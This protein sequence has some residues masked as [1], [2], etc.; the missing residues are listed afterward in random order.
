[1]NKKLLSKK[2]VLLALSIA[3]VFGLVRQTVV[4]RAARAAGAA[5]PA[6]SVSQFQHV[7]QEGKGCAVPKSWGQLKG[8][9]DR[10]IAFEDSSGTIRVVDIG[11]CER[12][13][14]RLIVR[15]SRP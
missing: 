2:L 10:S 7:P 9:A 12:G 6:S 3:A 11:P 4:P 14:T 5:M 1:M 8:V 15:I 13:E